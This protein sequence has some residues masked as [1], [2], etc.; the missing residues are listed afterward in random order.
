[1][2]FLVSRGMAGVLTIVGGVLLGAGCGSSGT[3]DGGEEDFSNCSMISLKMPDAAPAKGILG[4]P[5]A[6]GWASDVGTFEVD[7]P[8]PGL[9]AQL[10]GTPTKEGTY[11]INVHFS[12]EC[13]SS[14]VS[15]QLE[16]ED[17]PPECDDDDDCSILSTPFGEVTEC[18]G[19]S[20]CISDETCV[21][22][23]RTLNVCVS[24]HRSGQTRCGQCLREMDVSPADGS[25]PASLCVVDEAQQAEC[26]MT[27]Y[28]CSEARHCIER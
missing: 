1:M 27:V 20:D 15:Y 12:N 9:D 4:E 22:V 23:T 7:A 2:S 13:E 10:Q 14:D 21:V 28:S 11:E 26:N 8:P 25:I 6:T 3:D 18:D 19:D 24:A 5:Y 16:I 17:L